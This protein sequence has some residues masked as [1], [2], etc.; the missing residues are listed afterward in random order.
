MPLIGQTNAGIYQQEPYTLQIAVEKYNKGNYN[1]ADMILERLSP[2]E[3]SQSHQ[4]IALLNMRIKYRLNDYHMSKEIGMSLL[5]EQPTVKL[6]NEILMTFGDIFNAEGSYDVAFRTFLNIFKNNNV[7]LNQKKII[8]KI[9]ITLQFGIS[10]NIPDELLSTEIDP[11]LIQILLLAKTHIELQVGQTTRAAST[12]SQI[13]SKNLLDVNREYYFK[14]KDQLNIMSTGRVIVGVVLPLTGK[15]AKIGKEFLDGLRYAELNN[16]SINAELSII[17]YDNAGDELKTL[18]AFQALSKNPNI[19]AIIGPISATNSIIAGSMADANGIP[20]ILPSITIDGLAKIS[21][22][23]FLM[24]S[25]L[26]TRG[27]LAAKLMVET[28]QVENIAVLAPADKFG[29]S[30]V[31]A[32]TEKLAFYNQSPQIVE[33]YS[34]IPMNLTRQ[35]KTIRSKAWDLSMRNSYTYFYDEMIA[36]DSSKIVLNSIDAIYMPIHDGHLDYIGAQFPIYNIDAIVV[37]NDNW[38]DLDV[39]RKENIGPHFKGAYVISNYNNFNI[40]LLNN[41]F[42]AK[43]TAYFYQAFDCF[44]LLTKSITEAKMLNIS[45][46]QHLSDIDGFNGLFGTYNFAD[47]DYNVNAT[48]NIMQ[49]D[50][51]NF[52][53]YIDQNQQFHY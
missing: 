34:G 45:L 53:K 28:L 41:N 47:S 2:F 38:A 35:F 48:L 8:D 31:D 20:L 36:E 24:N 11:T 10:P 5:L 40:D 39:L 6:K 25:D 27:S 14:L 43:H 3:K 22:N 23:I 17:V 4:E 15:D 30:L 9:F 44:N 49:F 37:G 51:F 50:G 16:S 32:F 19:V 33:W 1:E 13:D 7:E 46:S 18:E 26:K 12:I 52:D 29:K 21:N 42:N